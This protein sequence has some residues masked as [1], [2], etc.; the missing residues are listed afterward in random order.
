MVLPPR[1]LKVPAANPSTNPP[2]VHHLMIGQAARR[3]GPP[4]SI[5]GMSAPPYYAF[6]TRPY[7][8]RT[9]SFIISKAAAWE[10]LCRISFTLS[11]FS[12][13]GD[14]ETLDEFSHFRTDHMSTKQLSRLLVEDGLNQSLIFTERNRLAICS[15]E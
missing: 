15:N 7:A 8:S 9:L 14:H 5:S 4:S 13:H 11:R 2:T 12:V 10:D 6:S 1:T 3:F